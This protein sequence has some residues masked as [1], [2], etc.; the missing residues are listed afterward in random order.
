MIG[1]LTGKIINKQKETLILLVGGVGYL[2]TPLPRKL[3]STILDQEDHL[4]IYTD[5]KDDAIN[6]YGFSSN[7]ELQLFKKVLNVSGIGPKTA[8]LVVD[9]GVEPVEE[10]II[11]SNLDFFIDIPRLGRKNA[12]KLI[13]ELKNKIGGGADID[14]TSDK[15]Q[16]ELIE[17]LI[18]MGYS[19][20]EIYPLLSKASGET[21]EDKLTSI[22]KNKD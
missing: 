4:Y 11:K 22:L 3:S 5:V 16:S 15:E 13:I 10:A 18:S 2:I 1:Y 21:I 17:A 14:L 8:L 9:K 6:L 20:N 12:Q 7:E 19:K